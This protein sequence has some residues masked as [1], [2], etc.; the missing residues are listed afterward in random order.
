LCENV[1]KWIREKVDTVLAAPQPEAP[2]CAV[3]GGP[4]SRHRA[5]ALAHHSECT[6]EQY[7]AQ[8]EGETD[9]LTAYLTRQW[10]WSARTF[11]PGKR[12]KGVV[13]HIRKELTEV[14]AKP[15]DLSE[16]IDVIILAM[17]GYWRHGGKVDQLLA[18]LQA[19]Q[20]KNFARKWPTPTSEDIAVEHD[21]SEDAASYERDPEWCKADAAFEKRTAADPVAVAVAARTR[22]IAGL[23]VGSYPYFWIKE[24]HPEAFAEVR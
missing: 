10:E 21:R 15:H 23:F 6:L 19:K 14:L 16:W 22:E 18:D 7:R 3:C 12:T 1:A 11:G 13:E 24:R 8:P 17:D 4:R 9:A 20:D 2:P 5:E